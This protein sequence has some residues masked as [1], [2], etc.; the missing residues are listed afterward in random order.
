MIMSSKTNQLPPHVPLPLL[1]TSFSTSAAPSSSSSSGNNTT[2]SSATSQDPRNSTAT[3]Q[4]NGTVT[5]E[6][7]YVKLGAYHTLDLEGELERGGFERFDVDLVSGRRVRRG[8]EAGRVALHPHPLLH[9]H[10]ISRS[11][12]AISLSFSPNHI[13]TENQD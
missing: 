5:N 12:H 6:N 8:G 7:D 3:L 2:G 13:E 1:Q 11:I 9:S 4:I 10:P